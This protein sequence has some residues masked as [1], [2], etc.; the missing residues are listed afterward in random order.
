M[1]NGTWTWP[2]A[3][4]ALALM[5]AAPAG[6]TGCKS[7]GNGAEAFTTSA[8]A[9]ETCVAKDE[10][11]KPIEAAHG[12]AAYDALGAEGKVVRADFDVDFGG[13]DLLA[14]TMWFDTGVGK[15]R[16]EL[17]NGTVVVFDGEACW[18][19]AD[20]PEIPYGYRFHALTWPYFAAAPF[21]L[22]DPGVSH[23]FLEEVPLTAK[24][25]S[26]ASKMTFEAGLGDAPDD[27]YVVFPNPM[28]DSLAALAYIVT[29][30]KSAEVAEKRP[31]IVFYT[32]PVTVEGV[33]F[34]RELIFH[35]WN[36]KK[37]VVGE[38]KGFM[39]VSDVAFVDAPAGAFDQP[40]GGVEAALLDLTEAAAAEAEET[41][42]AEASEAEDAAV[43][44][45]SP[46]EA[47]AEEAAESVQEAASES[48]LTEGME[49]AADAVEDAAEEVVEA[50]GDTMD[51]AAETAEDVVDD[52]VEA[53]TPAE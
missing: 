41:A 46:V 9:C 15:T 37:G 12:K 28:D 2:T 42:E 6:L 11:V 52:A 32:E 1:R 13:G 35:F 26:V 53:V 49:S 19:S 29:Y 5:V 38:P 21:K 23:E 3:G 25:S 33:T 10:V 34:A 44:A 43:D 20:A 27:W 39:S 8:V 24:A 36:R 50:T 48:S 51:A 17:D 22:S 18:T 14:G 30:D 16:M 4:L 7:D 31:S 45:E 47:A 40:E